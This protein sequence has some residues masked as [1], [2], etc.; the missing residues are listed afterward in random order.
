MK[1]LF[2]KTPIVVLLIGFLNACDLSDFGD[3]NKD[4]N[5]PTEAVTAYLLTGA[6]VSTRSAVLGGT[7]RELYIQ[8]FSQTQYPGASIYD[9]FARWSYYGIYRNLLFK[10]KIIIDYNKDAVKKKNAASYGNNDAQ[11]ALAEIYSCYLFQMVTDLV[12]PIPYSQA[13]G[14][15]KYNYKPTFDSQESIYKDL[16]KRIEKAISLINGLPSGAKTVQGDILFSG[17]MTKWK[18]FA[19]MLRATMAM[20]ISD[21]DPTLARA[22]F[23][24]SENGLITKNDENLGFK[25]LKERSWENPWYSRYR[26]REDYAI[27]KPLVDFLKERK[28]KRL[29]IFAEKTADLKAKKDF[30][31]YNGLTYG[32]TTADVGAI[33]KSSYSYPHKTGVRQQDK[34]LYYYTYAQA[35]FLKAEAASKGWISG[36]AETFYNDAIKASMA[37]WDVAD[38][39]Y[40]A[41]YLADPK[42]KWDA[43]KAKQLIGEQKWVALFLQGN[44]AYASWRRLDYPKLKP[45]P[46][47]VNK[48]K[49]IPLRHQYVQAVG[50]LN[51][52][53]YAKAKLLLGG[54][55][56][57]NDQTKLWW[58]KN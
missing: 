1:N 27:S 58:D 31:A 2:I 26:S 34:T 11:I 19:N 20:R 37:Q 6:L 9:G 15:G 14:E 43:A 4:P 12:G 5:N 50:D 30:A 3:T 24:K 55:D 22:E 32:L 38:G 57:D 36:N 46:G 23:L 54:S 52:T 13:L 33:K 44:E 53:G 28:D 25:F 18:R 29:F 8:Y 48:S 21:A 35:A 41:T 7:T 51:D 40:Y 42:V 45:A 17:N 10:L 39:G 47:A 16:F 56:S 49:K